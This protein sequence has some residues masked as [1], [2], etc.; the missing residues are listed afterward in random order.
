VGAIPVPSALEVL[1]MDHREP[2]SDARF[3]SVFGRV[4]PIRIENL[5][6]FAHVRLL[7]FKLRQYRKTGLSETWG[8]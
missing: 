1:L 8:G 2:F 7:I 3:N 6:C 4:P 5:F